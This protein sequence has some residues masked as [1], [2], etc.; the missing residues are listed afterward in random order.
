MLPN[1]RF[2]PLLFTKVSE[3]CLI[4]GGS[5]PYG[6]WTSL[7]MSYLLKWWVFN[8]YVKLPE[9]FGDERVNQ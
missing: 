8:S 7:W 3:G 4:L 5:D 2:H 6:T 9:E 1:M